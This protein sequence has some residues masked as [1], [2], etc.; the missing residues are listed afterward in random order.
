ML[1]PWL[2]ETE[3]MPARI[4]KGELFVAHRN[5]KGEKPIKNLRRFISSVFQYFTIYGSSYMSELLDAMPLQVF[6]RYVW[7]QFI[8]V[9]IITWHSY[10]LPSSEI[11]LR[12]KVIVGSDLVNT[13]LIA[14]IYATL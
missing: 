4:R 10:K 11:M 8:Q 9:I 1:S 7:I 3:N 13:T 6:M 2:S 5:L 12:N 14:P